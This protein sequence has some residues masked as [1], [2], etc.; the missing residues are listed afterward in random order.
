MA[1]VARDPGPDLEITWA[2]RRSGVID[3]YVFNGGRRLAA[4]LHLT[5]DG[6]LM[7]LNAQLMA[8]EGRRVAAGW[9]LAVAEFGA[10]GWY[11]IVREA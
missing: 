4:L 10:P 3:V 6:G 1:V 5:G 11:A 7:L 9:A 2:S 8:P